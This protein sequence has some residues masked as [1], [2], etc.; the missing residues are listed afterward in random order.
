MWAELTKSRMVK[1][2]QE[3]NFLA[4]R[5]SSC[6]NSYSGTGALGPLSHCTNL[7]K[8]CAE[9]GI[10]ILLR[11][12]LNN[13]LALLGASWY[14]L[15]ILNRFGKT[16]ILEEVREYVQKFL[17]YL[18]CLVTSWRR[19]GPSWRCLSR[20][21]MTSCCLLDDFLMIK[22]QHEIVK[23]TSERFQ[24]AVKNSRH[25]RCYVTNPPL[26]VYTRGQDR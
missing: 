12:F 24:K 19:L 8:K 4:V 16:N 10:L 9:L 11:D 5:H 3:V 6:S 13:F 2:C 1:N 23:K 25:N 15:T 20:F 7:N 14:F 17:D 18:T 22:K 26:C 21:L